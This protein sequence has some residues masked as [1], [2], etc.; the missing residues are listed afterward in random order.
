MKLDDP[1]AT[2]CRANI[3]AHIAGVVAN[4]GVGMG[5]AIVHE[6]GEGVGGGL[7][8][9]GLGGYKGAKGDE[10]GGVDGTSVDNFLESCGARGV[11]GPELSSAGVSGA[12][13]P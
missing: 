8:S 2:R 13:A 1:A 11:H 5:S 3:E 12:K 6:M 10:T 7:C 4:D 9:V